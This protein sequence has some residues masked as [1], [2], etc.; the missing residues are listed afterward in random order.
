MI[1]G[2]TGMGNTKCSERDCNIFRGAI[3]ACDA[4]HRHVNATTMDSGRGPVAPPAIPGID[5]P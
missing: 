5:R 1:H 3:T 4:C 2:Q